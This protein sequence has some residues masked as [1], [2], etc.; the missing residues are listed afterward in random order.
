L[1]AATP[2][3]PAK[4]TVTPAAAAPTFGRFPLGVM[5]SASAVTASFLPS[6]RLFLIE[7]VVSHR[8]SSVAVFL[9]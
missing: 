5:S 9:T 8:L 6:V 3:S 2:V 4:P 7:S 1:S